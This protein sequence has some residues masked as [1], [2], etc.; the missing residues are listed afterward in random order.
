[1]MTKENRCT[2]LIGVYVTPEMKEILQLYAVYDRKSTSGLQRSINQ[3][4][5]QKQKL[6]KEKLIR[7]LATQIKLD[8]DIAVHMQKANLSASITKTA[9]LWQWETS[10]VGKIGKDLTAE[11]IRVYKEEIIPKYG[12]D[13]K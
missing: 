4:W 5:I 11:V 8:W 13:N 3:T 12:T 1:M 6:T 2:E 7:L 10:L 9:F